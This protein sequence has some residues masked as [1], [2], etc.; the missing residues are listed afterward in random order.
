MAVATGRRG[1]RERADGVGQ[2]G[3]PGSAGAV[4]AGEPR[5]LM[6][7]ANA[8]SFAVRVRDGVE[9]DAGQGTDRDGGHGGRGGREVGTAEAVGRVL[10]RRVVD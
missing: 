1:D 9:V 4:G 8:R 10:V 7:S 3:R 2:V 6:P 5:R